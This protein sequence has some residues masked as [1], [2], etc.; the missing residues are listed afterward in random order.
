MSRTFVMSTFYPSEQVTHGE[1]P[2]PGHRQAP[3]AGLRLQSG[4]KAGQWQCNSCQGEVN[5]DQ[6]F[7]PTCSYCRFV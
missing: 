3:S 7:R 6:L 2:S 4:L 1:A 5:G